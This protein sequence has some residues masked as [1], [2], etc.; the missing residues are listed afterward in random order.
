MQSPS[1]IVGF[2]VRNTKA[3]LISTFLFNQI[4]SSLFSVTFELVFCQNPFAARKDIVW[5]CLFLFLHRQTFTEG[6]VSLLF[7]E[8]MCFGVISPPPPQVS[9]WD[10]SSQAEVSLCF[11]LPPPLSLQGVLDILL[12]LFSTPLDNAIYVV[13]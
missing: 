5:R 6:R 2:F 9:S 3:L 4:V 1:G 10:I 11:S 8:L 13:V 7:F 12:T